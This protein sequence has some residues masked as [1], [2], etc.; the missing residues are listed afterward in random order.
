M[1]K[2]LWY[3]WLEAEL[4]QRERK[5]PGVDNQRI[6]QYWT[7]GA[8]PTPVHDDETPWCA[9]A[10]N[11]ALVQSGYPGTRSGMARS[12]REGALFVPCDARLGA[13]V[14]LSST[15]G[16]AS[17]HVGLLAGISPT[18]VQLLGGNQ[19]DAVSVATF[20]RERVLR[21]LWPASAPAYTQ[22]PMAPAIQ[23]GAPTKTERDD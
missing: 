23:D 19:G 20:P 15:R 7:L 3:R 16:P 22:Y 11:A 5:A 8:I 18:H 21:T 12:F 1:I 17:G 14:V 9:A 13:I 6:E 10:V 2:Q 4:G